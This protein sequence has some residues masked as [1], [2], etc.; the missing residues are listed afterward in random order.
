MNF[1]EVL[2]DFTH[3]VKPIDKKHNLKQ[4]V[5]T[6]YLHKEPGEK[7]TRQDMKNL[8]AKTSKIKHTTIKQDRRIGSQLMRKIDLIQEW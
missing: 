1:I 3:P 5:A 4:I 7:F 2:E 8:H 6:N